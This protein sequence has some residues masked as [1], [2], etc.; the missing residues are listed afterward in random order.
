MSSRPPLRITVLRLTATAVV[1]AVLVWSVLYLDLLRSHAGAAVAQPTNRQ[2]S[3]S[4]SR[5]APAPV[6]TRTS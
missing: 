2:V 4:D 3:P 5:P 1:A 6:T